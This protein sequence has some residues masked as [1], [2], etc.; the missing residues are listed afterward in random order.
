MQLQERFGGTDFTV[1][2]L[3]TGPEE[4]ARAFSLQH[5]VN[6]PI[7]AS[8]SQDFS[9]YD[10]FFV[11]ETYLVA[12]DGMIVADSLSEAEAI[13]AEALSPSGG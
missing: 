2:A 9:N 7:Q 8:S 13:L 1:L 5:R 4:E 11:P 10:I 12:P 6:Y 3:M